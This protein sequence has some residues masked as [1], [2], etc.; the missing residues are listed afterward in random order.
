MTPN[1]GETVLADPRLSALK[2]GVNTEEELRLLVK[3]NADRGVDIIKSRGTERAGLPQTDPRKMAYT[4]EQLEI[5]V[6]EA[7][8]FNLKVMVHAHGDEGARAAVE[9]G[10]RC[11]GQQR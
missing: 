8:K 7:S 11:V 1:L 9:A 3:I 4:R 6:D 2:G 5:I 10:A